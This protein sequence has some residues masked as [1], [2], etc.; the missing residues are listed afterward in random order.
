MRND[1]CTRE[2]LWCRGCL[3]RCGEWKLFNHY[4]LVTILMHPGVQELVKRTFPDD[5]LKPNHIFFDNNCH[6]SK[7]VRNDPYFKD[8]GLSVDV[9]HFTCKHLVTD[10]WCQQN[11]NPWMFEDLKK[12]DGGW[13]FNSSIA[14]QTNVWLG[15]YH[16]IC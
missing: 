8:I 11:C 16:S 10:T 6:L 1:H 5:S 14:E 12:P 4:M 15:G 7:V 2:V 9:F 13:F 3:Q